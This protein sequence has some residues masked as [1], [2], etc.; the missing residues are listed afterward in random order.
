MDHGHGWEGEAQEGGGLGGEGGEGEGQEGGWGSGGV[1]GN[2]DWGPASICN[3]LFQV[4][5]QVG[6]ADWR[7]RH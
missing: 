4:H 6:W 2:T 5:R 7:G 3:Q 1:E